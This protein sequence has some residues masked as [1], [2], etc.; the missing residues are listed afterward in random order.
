MHLSKWFSAFL[1][2][3]LA[4]AFGGQA[5]AQGTIKVAYTDP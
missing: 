5:S 2:L 3:M 4:I 1:G